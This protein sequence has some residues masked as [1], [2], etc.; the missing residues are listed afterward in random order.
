MSL[1]VIS[2]SSYGSIKA[3]CQ[4]EIRV[5]VVA[6]AAAGDDGDGDITR[7]TCLQALMGSLH[8]PHSPFAPSP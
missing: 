4:Q 1:R 7:K 6:A 5:V 8:A 3:I 2:T